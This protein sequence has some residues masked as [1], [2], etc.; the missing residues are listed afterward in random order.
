MRAWG[1]DSCGPPSVRRYERAPVGHASTAA[2]IRSAGLVV[3]R[4]C[5]PD[6]TVSEAGNPNGSTDA[7]AALTNERRNVAAIMP[8]PERASEP[9][10]GS[11]GG[12][13]MIESFAAAV[14]AVPA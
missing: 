5:N 11:D 2:A 12:K 7:I 3:A 10:L 9:I 14:A 13:V 1:V 6:G 4:Y 8:H